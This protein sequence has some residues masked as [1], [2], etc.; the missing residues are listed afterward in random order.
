[1]E[2]GT[3]CL[4]LGIELLVSVSAGAE[5]GSPLDSPL[6]CIALPSTCDLCCFPRACASCRRGAVCLNVWRC[7][8][9]VRPSPLCL[10]VS[11]CLVLFSRRRAVRG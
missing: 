1:M 11:L 7:V 9:V 3:L 4:C 10:S 8:S 2:L 5:F 6:T